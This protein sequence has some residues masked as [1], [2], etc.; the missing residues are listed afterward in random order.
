MCAWKRSRYTGTWG[1]KT[2]IPQICVQLSLGGVQSTLVLLGKKE[3]GYM[4]EKKYTD[5]EINLCL[6]QLYY[7]KGNTV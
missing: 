7:F 3:K 6:T 5:M 1:G 2:I 4:K